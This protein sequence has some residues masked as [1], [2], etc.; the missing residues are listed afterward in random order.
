[1]FA[2]PLEVLCILLLLLVL[3]LVMLQRCGTA[4]CL[5]PLGRAV[6]RLAA[7]V[8]HHRSTANAVAAFHRPPAWLRPEMKRMNERTLEAQQAC[9]FCSIDNSM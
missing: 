7:F 8:H 6:V 1:V 5:A 9:T 4:T 2:I 3:V